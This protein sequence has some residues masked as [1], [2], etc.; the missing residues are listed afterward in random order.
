MIID[1]FFI[2]LFIS[3]ICFVSIFRKENSKAV[4][5]VQA[6]ELEMKVNETEKVFPKKKSRSGDDNL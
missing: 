6:R 4:F 5:V 1:T 3:S 2:L